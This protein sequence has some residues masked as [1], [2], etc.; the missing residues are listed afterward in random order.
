MTYYYMCLGCGAERT[1][2][3]VP[4]THKDA[5]APWCGEHEQSMQMVRI[6]E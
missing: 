1:L 3:N 5:A 4:D 6:S 2:T